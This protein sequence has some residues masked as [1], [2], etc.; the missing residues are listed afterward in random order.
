[1]DS[2]IKSLEKVFRTAWGNPAITEWGS[3]MIYKYGD[4]AK[5]IVYIHL[6]FEELGI[7][8]GDKVAV[9]DKNSA[10]WMISTLA[11]ITYKAV[12]V[13]L[14]ADYS[15][16]QI[17][18]LCE[19]CDA[20]FMIC[21]RKMADLWPEG[22][23]PMYLLDIADLLTMNPSSATDEVEERAFAQYAKR[24]PHGYTKDDVCY[25]AEN[26]DDL[27]LLSYTSGSTGNPKGVMLSYRSVYSN[28]VYGKKAFPI[29]ENENTL[30]VLPM[31]HM[32][33]FTFDFLHGITSKAHIHVLT[34][35]PVPSVLMKAFQEVRPA[36][37]L[38][39]PL[40]MEKIVLGKVAPKLK[41][42]K[43][44]RMMRIPGLRR[45]VCAK[46]C[47]EML[48]FFGGNVRQIAMGGA[49]LNKDVEKILR[50]V[51]FPGSVGY[52]MTECGPLI[53]FSNSRQSRF[54]SCGRAVSQMEIQVLSEE[55]RQ[56]PGEI[57][58]RGD[59]VMLGY[60]K[61]PDAS[62]ETIDKD[63]WMHTGDLGVLDEDGFLYIRGRKKNMLLGS[64]GQ[65][66]FPEEAEEQVVSH[67]LFDE[68]VVVQREGKLVALVY[69][70]DMT[71]RSMQTTREEV[72]K[73]LD[74]VCAEI[75]SYLPKY[76]QLSKMEQR[77]D[78]FEKTPK[79]SIRRF[80]YK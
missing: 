73:Q 24:Y 71:L 26:P 75:N 69:A 66:I 63:G 2:L 62:E 47:R 44:Q 61:N 11:I 10:N 46:V 15:E 8:P 70:S 33:G 5:R 55:P 77:S 25:E 76:C 34:K 12:A 52:G 4:I 37:F 67:S 27:M 39:V 50:M 45:I 40:I 7:K 32:F 35:A 16:K 72:E 80:L 17:V 9:C 22:K 43:I 30:I 13:P 51:R 74:T 58:V 28:M 41:E 1:M 48:R 36:V 23:C 49:G 18:M 78:E 60:Y 20:K 56:V 38:C 19:H 21:N 29:S 65:N 57:V 68:C 53:A 31:A 42:P 14:L 79:K 54:A 3:D 64:N 59:N 6:L